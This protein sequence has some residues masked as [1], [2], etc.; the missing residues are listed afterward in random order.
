MRLKGVCLTFVVV[1]GALVSG[2]QPAETR[3]VFV[4]NDGALHLQAWRA[5]P[6]WCEPFWE[7]TP[8]SAGVGLAT[9]QPQA[10]PAQVR[11]KPP[12]PTYDASSLEARIAAASAKARGENRRVLVAWGSNGDQPSQALIELTVRNSEVSQK[13][14]Y[15]YD[16]VRA[17]PAGNDGMAAKLGADVKGG[18]LPRLTVLDTDGRVLANEPAETFKSSTPGSSAF[19]PKALVAFLTK[20]QAPYLDAEA[21]LTGALSRAKKDQKTL[22]LWFSAPW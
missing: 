18:A 1:L 3:A 9:R 4:T 5:G 14:L 2:Q 6:S 8:R 19:D 11:P 22:F 15:E 7:A 21:L 13:L 12:L 20:H 16:V 10:A 17:D